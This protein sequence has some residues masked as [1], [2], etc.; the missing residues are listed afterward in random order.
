MPKVWSHG[1]SVQ[2]AW[3]QLKPVQRNGRTKL[4]QIVRPKGKRAEEVIDAYTGKCTDDEALVAQAAYIEAH[5][6]KEWHDMRGKHVTVYLF[7]T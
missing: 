4:R 2:D 1:V 3:N 5:D 6:Y 7:A